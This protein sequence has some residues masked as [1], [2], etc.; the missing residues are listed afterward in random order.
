MFEFD[1]PVR[2]VSDGLRV[3]DDENRVPGGMQLVQ[4]IQD[5]GLVVFIEIACGFI[6]KNQFRMIDQ[7]ARDGHALL[8]AA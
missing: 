1:A 7:R 4:K 6:R 8:L 2:E 3:S 5:R